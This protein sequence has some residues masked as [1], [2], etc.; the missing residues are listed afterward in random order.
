MTKQKVLVPYNFTENDRKAVDFVIRMFAPREDVAVTL[1]SAY[2]PAPEIET[3]NNTIMEKM[4]QNLTYL[5]QRIS[6]QEDKIKAVRDRLVENGFSR[7]RVSY[8][9][10]PVKKDISQDIVDLAQSDGFNVI[11]LNR[12]SGKISRFFTGHVFQKVVMGVE[13]VVVLIVT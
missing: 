8:L 9:F 5:R 7:D 3:R 10:T 11:V 12:T 6:E 2:T 4:R 1:F 13:D